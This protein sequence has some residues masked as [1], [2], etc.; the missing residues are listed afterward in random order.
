MGSLLKRPARFV[1]LLAPVAAGLIGCTLDD[2]PAGRGDAQA[3]LERHFKSLRDDQAAVR[4]A[5]AEALGEIGRG[6]RRTVPALTEA[7]KDRDTE[8]RR[9]AAYALA[10]LGSEAAG[11]VP[12]LTAA[13]GDPEANVRLTA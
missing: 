10:R 2:P 5:A 3:Q 4:R 6:D 8:V 1:S 9:E 7:L 13:L 11:A 12:A